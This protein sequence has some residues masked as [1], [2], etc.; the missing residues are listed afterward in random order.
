MPRRKSPKKVNEVAHKQSGVTVDIKLD[1]ET[2]IF[3]AKLPDDTTI[4]NK[5]G[6]ALKREVM[7]WLHKNMKLE[8]YAAIEVTPLAP[9]AASKEAD[10]FVGFSLRR[11]YWAKKLDGK[12]Y[13][14]VDL[15]E[16]DPRIEEKPWS[17]SKSFA[18]M[19]EGNADFQPPTKSHRSLRADVYYLV[20]E[21][22]T[23]IGL[24]QMVEAIQQLNRRLHDMLSTE[25]GHALIAQ[26]GA[27]ILKALPAPE[28]TNASHE[29][30]QDGH[31]QN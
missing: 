22:E 5:D 29:H 13:M 31:G 17:W 4:S 9:F 25:E 8:W 19:I 7:Q 3:S 23:W 14:Q 12:G 26:V 28:D 24:C 20:Y 6:E 1:H 18:P 2:L 15:W 11:F 27:N 10:H 30:V 16:H 21:E